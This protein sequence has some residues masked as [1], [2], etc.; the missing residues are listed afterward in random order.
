MLR[1]EF[2]AG[3]NPAKTGAFRCS[4]PGVR[5]IRAANRRDRRRVG[6]GAIA[7]GGRPF[8]GRRGM[9]KVFQP[10]PERLKKRD[11]ESVAHVPVLFD[12]KQRY[13]RAY[14]RYLRER[15]LLEWS[16]PGA[17]DYPGP[18]TLK[19]MADYLCN[20]IEWCEAKSHDWATVSY[21][22]VL[23]YQAD[24]ENGHWSAKGEPLKPSTANARTDEVTH[25]LTWADAAGLR[26]KFDVKQTPIKSS[27]PGRG[28]V[29][30]RAGKAKEDRSSVDL[31]A[32]RLPMPEEVRDWLF[33]VR[34]RRG[35]AKY[36][37]CR[38]VIECGPRRK[39]VAEMRANQ[40]PDAD[41][42]EFAHARGDEFIPMQLKYGTKG[43]RPRTI[44][45]PTEY[46]AEV[47]RWIEGPRSTYVHRMY[48]RSRERT[49]RLFVSDS[50]G[51]EGTPISVDTIYKC[52]DEV[53]PRP[54]YWH[55]HLG[56]HAYACFVIL[57]ALTLDAKAAKSKLEDMDA[58]W[59]ESRGKWWLKTLSRQLG[60][61][62]ET[63][64]EIYLRWLITASKL[65]EMAVGWHAYLEEGDDR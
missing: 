5:A 55:P 57:H 45:I 21:R 13:C 63:T 19:N 9:A 3:G 32:F 24:Q 7:A 17:R 4:T 35:T 41:T 46:A 61:A 22:D 15:A 1:T 2:T 36:L 60:H 33:A 43:R 10:D 34:S 51:Y 50:A 42:I 25:F 14:N 18:Q 26:G 39:E 52:F 53:K 54:R 64:T 23:T 37:A 8:V 65:A 58:D 38:F 44:R 30:A 6:A 29:M 20:W 59:V 48:K 40:W 12:G 11:F 47:R 27:W 28:M 56:R 49:D 62:S 31:K 16:P